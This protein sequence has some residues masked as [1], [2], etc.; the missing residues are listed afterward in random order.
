M[1]EAKHTPGPWR[2]DAVDPEL[3][4]D[5]QD[6]SIACCYQQPFDTWKATDNA[7][8]VAASPGLLDLAKRMSGFDCE[9]DVLNPCDSDKSSPVGFHWAGGE[10]CPSCHA[11]QL[12]L[13][14]QP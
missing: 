12:I 6:V 14:T 10:A 9:A 5:V 3:V 1:S 13:K 11:R 2:I 7:R 8:L 4:V